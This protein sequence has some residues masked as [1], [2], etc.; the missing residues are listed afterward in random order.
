MNEL[1]YYINFFKGI[2][3]WLIISKERK[4]RKCKLIKLV[5]KWLSNI[6]LLSLIHVNNS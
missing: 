1:N 6:I 2:K 4:E 5:N 3:C